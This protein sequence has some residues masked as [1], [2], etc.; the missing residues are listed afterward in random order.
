M[1]SN[2]AKHANSYFLFKIGNEHSRLIITISL[3]TLW[4]KNQTFVEAEGTNVQDLEGSIFH[5]Q[6]TIVTDL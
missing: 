6:L 5:D 2:I 4:N 3:C 1:D